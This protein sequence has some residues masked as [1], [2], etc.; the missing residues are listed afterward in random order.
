MI[1]IFSLLHNELGVAPNILFLI[2]SY[3]SLS[4]PVEFF[5]HL[6]L[7]YLF[8]QFADNQLVIQSGN[9]AMVEEMKILAKNDT[10]EL[11]LLFWIK[12]N[13]M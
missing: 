3:K 5:Y 11:A 9:V 1:W 7:L 6:W 12:S 10:W 4:L 13:R 8:L 2:V